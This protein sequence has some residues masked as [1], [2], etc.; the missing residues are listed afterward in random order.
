[1]TQGFRENDKIDLSYK[2]LTKS[3]K[4]PIILVP[5][6]AYCSCA[7]VN[8]CVSSCVR[9]CACARFCVCVCFELF[10]FHSVCF[11]FQKSTITFSRIFKFSSINALITF[12]K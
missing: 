11:L 6:H 12:F 4:L 10:Y 1:M 5:V 7:C 2:I 9:A 3:A 8:A